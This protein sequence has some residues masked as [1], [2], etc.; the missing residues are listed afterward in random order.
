VLLPDRA[1]DD[2]TPDEPVVISDYPVP[3]ID[4][5]VPTS[6]PR[7]RRAAPA[8]EKAAVGSGDRAEGDA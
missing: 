4:L 7:R 3:P 8:R 5:T 1:A 2:G 6:P